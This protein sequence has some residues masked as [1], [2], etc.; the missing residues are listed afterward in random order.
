M[1][2]DAYTPSTESAGEPNFER[3]STACPDLRGGRPV[4]GVSTAKNLGWGA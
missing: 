3:N 1:P 2:R 4:M